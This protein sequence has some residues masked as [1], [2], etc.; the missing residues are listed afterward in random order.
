MASGIE[1]NIYISFSQENENDMSI[2]LKKPGDDIPVVSLSVGDC[3][4]VTKPLLDEIA[5]IPYILDEIQELPSLRKAWEQ[6]VDGQR[7]GGISYQKWFHL[8]QT[9]VMHLY[10]FSDNKLSPRLQRA[11]INSYKFITSIPKIFEWIGL[12]KIRGGKTLEIDP[13]IEKY[14]QCKDTWYSPNTPKWTKS[15]STMKENPDKHLSIDLWDSN[16]KRWRPEGKSNLQEH[17]TEMLM[18]MNEKSPAPG[19][20]LYH[21]LGKGKSAASLAITRM[22]PKRKVLV[23]V[24]AS[25]ADNYREEI[26][27]G[28]FGG[29]EFRRENEWVFVPC[30][31]RKRSGAKFAT[32]LQLGGEIQRH[33][34][35]QPFG[36]MDV[37]QETSEKEYG[38]I[39]GY[40]LPRYYDGKPFHNNL[41]SMNQP[42]VSRI[43]KSVQRNTIKRFGIVHYN[44]GG[45]TYRQL[46]RKGLSHEARLSF[47]DHMVRFEASKEGVAKKTIVDE[48]KPLSSYIYKFSPE[49]EKIWNQFSPADLVEQI[50][51][52]MMNYPEWNPFYNKVV[53]VDESH[54]FVS[55]MMTRL[56]NLMYSL[57]MR[58]PDTKVVFLSGTPMMN[59]PIEL[60][61]AFD[62]I[63]GPRVQYVF[64]N[65]KLP[66][67]AWRNNTK[68]V[69]KVEGGIRKIEVEHPELYWKQAEDKVQITYDPSATLDS[70]IKYYS[71]DGGDMKMITR[72]SHGISWSEGSGWKVDLKSTQNYLKEFVLNE[73]E[74]GFK[75]DTDLVSRMVRGFISY[76]G[77]TD[78]IS[79]NY[80]I[81]KTNYVSCEMSYYQAMIY[82]MNRR[83]E[84]E[85]ES[86]S[87]K[88][89]DME[90]NTVVLEQNDRRLQEASRNIIL[91][92]EEGTPVR[93]GPA[94][95]A[96]ESRSD[97][98]Q[99]GS[100][101]YRIFSRQA[102]NMTYPSYIPYSTF[103]KSSAEG[104]EPLDLIRKSDCI[105]K[106]HP[107]ADER[108]SLQDFSTKYAA[109]LKNI[110]KSPGLVLLYTFFR[111]REG[112]DTFEHILKQ[113]G[114]R[115]FE[116]VGVISP[117]YVSESDEVIVA[118]VSHPVPVSDDLSK[119]KTNICVGDVLVKTDLEVNEPIMVTFMGRKDGTMEEIGDETEV[120]I[121]MLNGDIKEGSWGSF[122]LVPMQY[123]IIS[124]GE[125]EGRGEL[126]QN[127]KS[128]RN[129]KGVDAAIL[130]I[131]KAG[132]EGLDLKSVR[133]VHVL[134]PFWNEVRVQQ[135]LGRGSRNH[136]HSYLEPAEQNVENFVYKA[137][138]KKRGM[139]MDKLQTKENEEILDELLHMDSDSVGEVK[140]IDLV[141]L[142]KVN[143][144]GKWNDKLNILYQQLVE[145]GSLT[146][147]E[148][149]KKTSERKQV[150]IDQALK[151]YSYYSLEYLNRKV[152]EKSQP[153]CLTPFT[154]YY[155]KN[156]PLEMYLQEVRDR[157]M[158]LVK[159][160]DVEPSMRT[161]IPVYYLPHYTNDDPRNQWKEQMIELN[162]MCKLK[163]NGDLQIAQEAPILKM[164]KRFDARIAKFI[165]ATS[166]AELIQ[167]RIAKAIEYVSLPLS[168][169]NAVF[170]SGAHKSDIMTEF[171]RFETKTSQDRLRGVFDKMV[172]GDGKKQPITLQSDGKLQKEHS[173]LIM[174]YWKKFGLRI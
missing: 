115:K 162:I 30:G 136:S 11:T 71:M 26:K 129:K 13:R 67:K 20:L 56:G 145:D 36:E 53:I 108:W 37:G 142:M 169:V 79:S 33:L 40:W 68:Q 76:Q 150:L 118:N 144:T 19:M 135:V 54:N 134:E 153:I 49:K 51:V 47:L 120:V 167:K 29:S 82:L 122:K 110:L 119:Y 62:F 61:F 84:S 168:E 138:I 55:Q 46:I 130:M 23:M 107:K 139:D 38:N 85:R 155:D 148:F 165:K 18:Y 131:T 102:C 100:G 105:L 156:I 1:M 90:Q 27:A 89:G 109:T 91:E 31:I 98:K 22:Y 164:V 12:Q 69:M 146:S 125:S 154:M 124:G 93:R 16:A 166:K 111:I 65:D 66:E 15:F 140:N 39:T 104:K 43:E 96:G 35:L 157:L 132:A 149:V 41:D 14:T 21:F 171:M 158:V 121:R 159:Q 60:L 92:A 50:C 151:I 44:A 74:N 75:T 3:M 45:S 103:D 114:G 143:D 25:L 116:E 28:G 2:F 126:V 133:Q 87:K 73:K 83:Y 6:I 172:I 97:E 94:S 7:E 42:C 161:K 81:S 52:N 174:S 24:P 173:D 88:M 80:P 70:L 160:G 78:G 128:L 64:Q 4:E 58:C 17:Q 152:K 106:S 8:W 101:L 10:R 34:A 48:T 5:P 117:R 99:M 86:F 163:S 147:D 137:V 57:R 112:I 72:S 63:K 113:Y 123:G 141:Q 77:K 32:I 170:L 95:G 127:F 59:H 9:C